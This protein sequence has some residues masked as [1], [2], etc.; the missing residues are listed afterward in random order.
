MDIDNHR[1][2]YLLPG[3]GTTTNETINVNEERKA[4]K[5]LELVLNSNYGSQTISNERVSHNIIN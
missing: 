1:I 2:K 3:S 5:E 4:A